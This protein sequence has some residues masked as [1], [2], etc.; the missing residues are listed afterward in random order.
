MQG[1]CGALSPQEPA[2]LA[3]LPGCACPHCSLEDTG[4]LQDGQGGGLCFGMLPQPTNLSLAA[5]PNRVPRTSGVLQA[6][7][8]M[9]WGGPPRAAPIS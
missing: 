5:A 6:S 9:V 2:H 4:S 1:E 7:A 8:D 3:G